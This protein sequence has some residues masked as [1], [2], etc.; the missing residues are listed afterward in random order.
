M[1]NP[2]NTIKR[3]GARFYVD[4]TTGTK[5]PGVTSVMQNLPKPFLKPWGEKLAAEFAVNNIDTVTSLVNSGDESAAVDLVKGAARRY[6][7]QAAQRGDEVHTMFEAM[8]LGQ[9]VQAASDELRVYQGHI[10]EFFNVV[11]PKFRHV[12]ATVWSEQHG[13]AGSFDWLADVEIDGEL[14]TVIGDTKTTKPGPNGPHEE[15]AL[16][17]SAYARAD[18]LMLGDGTKVDMPKID[19]GA[20]FHV[21]SEGWTF[22]PINIGD[23]VF[24]TFLGLRAFFEVQQQWNEWEAGAKA[25]TSSLYQSL[26]GAPLA[27]GPGAEPVKV[28]QPV[29]RAP[30]SKRVDA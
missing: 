24:Q 22:R 28:T 8:A 27:S 30:R 19:A 4:P 13:Y 29:R 16:Q 5:V 7:T 18:Y 10:T 26:V 12:E 3:G 1:T 23:D 17:L 21:R 14:V 15:V 9:T 11:K 2:L 20:V 6:T 25:K